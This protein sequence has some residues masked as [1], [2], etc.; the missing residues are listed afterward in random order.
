MKNSEATDMEKSC[1]TCYWGAVICGTRTVTGQERLDCYNEDS[2]AVFEFLEQHGCED[3]SNVTPE[4]GAECPGWIEKI[5]EPD[6]EPEPE[7]TPEE[8]EKLRLSAE[9]SDRAYL[10]SIGHMTEE[11]E[12]TDS[13]Y[14]AAD[15][16]YD[17]A[18]ERR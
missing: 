1:N 3:G 17:A 13:Y 14:H 4:W 9:V 18:R 11:G 15:F 10:I 6:P 5:I 12:L 8:Q 16:A 2:D 7:L